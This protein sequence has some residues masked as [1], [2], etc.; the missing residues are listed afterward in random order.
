MREGER[1]FW[2]RTKFDFLYS[3]VILEDLWGFIHGNNQIL[4]L[5]FVRVGSVAYPHFSRTFK[6][7]PFLPDL[8]AYDVAWIITWKRGARPLTQM[9]TRVYVSS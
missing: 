2:K 4:A 8:I 9:Y 1:N 5:S 7:V 3:F 6:N